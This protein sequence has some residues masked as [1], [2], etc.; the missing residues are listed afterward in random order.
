MGT[1]KRCPTWTTYSTRACSQE[2]RTLQVAAKTFPSI[3]VLDVLRGMG[4][5][6]VVTS[7]CPAQIDDAVVPAFAYRP[8]LRSVFELMQPLLAKPDD[9]I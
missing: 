5:R 3:R 8:A 1:N 6:A 4:D 2:N 9:R 7:I